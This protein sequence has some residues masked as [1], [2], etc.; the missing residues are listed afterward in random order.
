MNSNTKANIFLL[1]VVIGFVTSIIYSVYTFICWNRFLETK[2]LKI[3][4]VGERSIW[5]SQAPNER[6]AIV[7]YLD[8]TKTETLKN[9]LPDL[10]PDT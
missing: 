9:S 1:V 4:T 5:H 2:V 10:K 3:E 6:M 8:S 7:T